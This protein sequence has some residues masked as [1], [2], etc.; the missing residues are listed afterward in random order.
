MIEE[1]SAY[2]N[3]LVVTTNEQLSDG[4]LGHGQLTPGKQTSA[5]ALAYEE[6]VSR[7]H[8]PVEDL[9]TGARFTP[10]EHD[11]LVM[12]VGGVDEDT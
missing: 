11:E 4:T 10:G 9:A 5:K 3:V 12:E 8:S 7:K 2:D 6:A 1:A